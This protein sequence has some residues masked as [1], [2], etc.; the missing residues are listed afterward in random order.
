MA[1]AEGL[2]DAA[3]LERVGDHDDRVVDRL[4]GSGQA[5]EA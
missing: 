5:L 2:D 3:G 4:I 1:G